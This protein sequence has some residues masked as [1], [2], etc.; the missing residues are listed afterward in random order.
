LTPIFRKRNAA[1]LSTDITPLDIG[2]HLKI[3]QSITFLDPDPFKTT[4]KM[5]I[6]VR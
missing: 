6:P 5:T 4:A 3:L 1:S 2:V